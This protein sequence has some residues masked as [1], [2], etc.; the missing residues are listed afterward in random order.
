MLFSERVLEVIKRIPEGKV[1][2]YGGVARALGKPRAW[3]A[4]G[5]ALN[6]NRRP[7]VVP[8]HRVIMSDGGVGGYSSGVDEK[9]ALLRKEGVAVKDGKVVDLK[10]HLY[11]F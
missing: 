2:T 10:D 7:V 9:I 1:A 3:R 4:V 8:C 11:E 5:G 6:K